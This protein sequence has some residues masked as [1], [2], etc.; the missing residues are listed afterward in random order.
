MAPQITGEIKM[1]V[2]KFELET[3]T[4]EE[5]LAMDIQ[6]LEDQLE[7][8]SKEYP[9]VL[10]T[11]A[12]RSFSTVRRM[13]AEKKMG[14]PINLRTGFAISVKTGKAANEMTEDEWDEF[15]NALSERLN[16]DYPHLY[17]S[18]FSPNKNG[19]GILDAAEL[20]AEL[21]GPRAAEILNEFA[22]NHSSALSLPGANIGA[23][24]NYLDISQ[25][26]KDRD[27]AVNAGKARNLIAI[28]DMKLGQRTAKKRRVPTGKRR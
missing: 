19:N 9:L 17:K 6:T 3:F 5:W 28:W 1:T 7:K 27:A 18:L 8:L 22:G 14:I 15:Y 16:G 24:T 13:T 23:W 25:N 11:D 20:N 26:I 2:K 10:H 21:K 4:R 12:G